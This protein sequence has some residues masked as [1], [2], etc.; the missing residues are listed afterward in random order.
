MAAPTTDVQTAQLVPDVPPDP[1]DL[2][3]RDRW[4]RPLI[5][6]PAGQTVGH[7]RASGAG[8]PLE[9][10]TKLTEW[11]ERQ[12]SVGTLLALKG[13]TEAKLAELGSYDLDGETE[14]QRKE[15]EVAI[16]MLQGLATGLMLRLESIGPEPDK[17]LVDEHAVWK[18]AVNGIVEQ[19]HVAAGSRDRADL[20]TYLHDVLDAR[21]RGVDIPPIPERFAARYTIAQR[22][23]D[24]AAV[25]AA[26]IG[27]RWLCRE[28]F[29]VCDTW[30]IAG[31]LDAL[32]LVP[33]D[34][35]IERTERLR[36]RIAASRIKDKASI[37]AWLDRRLV[38]YGGWK[39]DGVLW[40]MVVA[41]NKS[42]RKMDFGGLAYT[43]QVAA[44]ADAV[45]YDP[46][47]Q[48]RTP[49]STVLPD[50]VDPAT[51]RIDAEAS[52]I[53]HS[54]V[55]EGICR[56][57]DV[58]LDEGRAA[59]A[60]AGDVRAMRNAS[61]N[62]LQV[63][64]EVEAPRPPEVIEPVQA[65][66]PVDLISDQIAGCRSVEE[67]LAL[68]AKHLEPVDYGKPGPDG[69][70]VPRPVVHWTDAHEELAGARAALLP[71]P[72]PAQ[73]VAQ[74]AAAQP[75]PV[76]AEIAHAD[77]LPLLRGVWSVHK[78]TWTPEHDA[79]AAERAA[80][81]NAAKGARQSAVA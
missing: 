78:D 11:K 35:M 3:E 14:E 7:T 16:G 42:G 47:T 45:F 74:P 1:A 44:Y 4:G 6:T 62:W 77:S 20:G 75:D 36:S 60:M 46:A 54:P 69:V 80:Q 26:T 70:H 52:L 76:L 71:P 49:Y 12:V 27:W 57:Y 2:I 55:G 66:Q 5:P 34:L 63:V 15:R 19:A 18:A 30:T 24:V 29:V 38:A 13:E 64:H 59:I 28:R 10:V 73:P 25:D 23:R 37:L 9:D 32:A 51:V 22:D 79:A 39:A 61:R 48:E 58:P 53:V 67:L 81:I 72:T 21:F 68:R 65:S 50:D 56:I 8:K 17:D 40:V 41:D 43:A 33:I 31:T